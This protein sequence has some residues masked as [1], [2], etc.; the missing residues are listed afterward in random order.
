MRGSD[1]QPGANSTINGQTVSFY[2]CSFAAGKPE[3]PGGSIVAVDE[4]I[5]IAVRDGTIS[6]G[7]LRGAQGKTSAADFAE[8]TGLERG[9][10]FGN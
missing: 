1:P 4:R 3:L 9:S 8:A 5:E 2:D 7:R 6:V 10:R